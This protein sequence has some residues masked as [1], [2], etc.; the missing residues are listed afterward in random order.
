[1][2]NKRLVIVSVNTI[3]N[4]AVWDRVE[5]FD[6]LNLKIEFLS[7]GSTKKIG[8][9]Y[10][11]GTGDLEYNIVIDG[12][13]IA[14]QFDAGEGGADY[15]PV[16]GDLC[17]TDAEYT[18]EAIGG[19]TTPEL[20]ADASTRV[21]AHYDASKGNNNILLF[22]ECGNDMSL[23]NATAQEAYDN[24]VDYCEARKL[25]G[26][27]IIV[28]TV[29]PRTN[30]AGQEAKRLVLNEMI[31]AALASNETWLDAIAD[32]GADS[33]I[34]SSGANLNTTYYSDGLHFT[35]A[36]YQIIYP[37][38]VRAINQVLGRSGA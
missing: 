35:N 32:I 1:M 24:L 7:A 29:T 18:V 4:I 19:S 10:T 3:K 13:S 12:N 9:T 37:Y 33:I 26:W 34:G 27:K 36:G 30:P 11:M 22:L 20:A 28:V 25:V 31:R 21:D 6:P 15:G 14:A 23:N 17:M 16:M 2:P 8:D 38:Y 5:K